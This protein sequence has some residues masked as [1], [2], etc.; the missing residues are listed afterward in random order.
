MK[1]ALLFRLA[2]LVTA[3]MCA[4]GASAHDFVYGGYY[5][6][7]LTDSTVA[8]THPTDQ[9]GVYSG[10]VIIPE[11][12]RNTS[13][14][15]YYT[16]TQIYFRAFEECTGLISV[17]IPNTVTQ[18]EP[19]AFKGCTSLQTVVMGK[20]C[21]FFDPGTNGYATQVFENCPNLT[22]ITCW[23]FNPDNSAEQDG[24]YNFDL[25]VCDNATLY[26]PR[27]AVPNYQAT[28]GWRL[29]AHIQE[30]PGDYNYDFYQDGVFYKIRGSGQVKVTYRDEDYNSYSGTVTVPGS[31]LYKNTGYDVKGIDDYAFRECVNLTGV[32]VPEGLDSIGTYAF[33]NCYVLPKIDIPHGVTYIGNGAF[34]GCRTFK[35]IIFPAG[36]T[37]IYGSTCNGCYALET[38]VFPVDLTNI[39]AGSFSYCNAIKTIISL[40]EIAPS[41]YN[42]YIFS[43]TVYENAT[44]YIPEDAY[45]NTYTSTNGYW[46]N[47]A[48]Q[49]PY[50]QYLSDAINAAGT[51]ITFSSPSIGNYPWLVKTNAGRTC[52]QSGNTGIHN[53]SS[54]MTATITG[55][56]SLSFDFKAWGQGSSSALDYCLFMVDGVT[57]FRYGARDNDWETYTVELDEGTHTLTW[58]Y[59]KNNIINRTGDYFAISNVRFTS[60]APEAYA[61]YTSSNTTLTF[62]YDNQR[63]SRTGT[64]YDLNTGYGVPLWYN[65]EITGD[66]TKVVFDPSFAGAR[67]TTTY[68]WFF[69]M[70]YLQA[71]TGMEYLNTSE[72]TNM[73]GMFLNC[74]NLTS[75]DLSHFNTSKVTDMEM[76][77]GACWGLASLD[78][79]SF[80]T[81]RVT[82]MTKMFT[83]C[84]NLNYIRVGSGWSTA[85]V[86]SS[87]EMFKACNV[88]VGGQGTTWNESNPTDK[89]YAHIDGGTSNPGYF[90]EKGPEAYACYTSSNTTLTFYYDNQR[91]S[92]TGTTYDLN[93]GTTDVAWDTDDTNANVTKVVFD[94]SFANARPTTTYDW[95]YD[96]VNLE[97]ITG[98]SYLNTS[99]VTNMAYMFL[100]CVKLTSL[101]VSHFNTS[102]V[103]DMTQMFYCTGLTNLDLSN[104]NTSKVTKMR[105][106]F[107]GSSNLRTIYVGN[108]WSTVAVEESYDMFTN[109]FSLVGG[110]GTTYDANH[111]DK[112]YAHIDG[113]PSNP[114]YFTAKNAAL[115]GDV[116][117]DGSVTISDVTA[118]IDLLL[119]GGT[120][121][122]P[123]A[124]CNG[125]SNVTISDVTAL[126]DYL[127]GGSW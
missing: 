106:M 127:L 24:Y 22:S 92:R 62:Y 84:Y 46:K 123:A 48:T 19:R 47:F 82:Y 38:V 98:M 110:Q 67:P 36:V 18:I 105:Y 116:N 41:L 76:M 13:T 109:C 85:A 79:S 65:D 7:I 16:V 8:I 126:I 97:S 44:L 73:M 43:S 99:E 32:N 52:A 113:G 26:V 10:N 21:S 125:D 68:A 63:S 103:T 75:L 104:F 64:T 88:L 122:N 86:T 57:K 69:D 1:K 118:L 42:S 3:M 5:Y 91:S 119:G 17:T 60:Y 50:D 31:V 124:D 15:K 37:K 120:I 28:E 58:S 95:F 80:N 94:P 9:Y 117:G 72:V 101:D 56:G 23:M 51:N 4:L 115:R 61:C 74:I 40:N 49:K 53:S 11:G 12:V 55:P 71:I 66:V 2:V 100:D 14:Y 90:T 6:T 96:M 59:T 25:S 108:D 30:A 20:N 34:Q 81:S 78:L 29:F 121:S 87:T 93:T 70:N 89:T 39:Y 107:Y 102:K 33:M 114:G 54:T 77:F 45:A 35:S 83:N 111:V 112:T 27:G